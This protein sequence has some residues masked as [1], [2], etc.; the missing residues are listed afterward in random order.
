MARK[1]T[2]TLY[3]IRDDVL[4]RDHSLFYSTLEEHH[5]REPTSLGLNQWLYTWQP[6]ILSSVKTA[7]K[8]GTRGLSSI[9]QFFTPSTPDDNPHSEDDND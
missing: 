2:A 5:R 7:A 8:L 4:P 6:V 1:Q 9:R 3:E